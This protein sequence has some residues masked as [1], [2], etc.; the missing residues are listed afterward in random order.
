MRASVWIDYNLIATEQILAA[1]G[2]A[3][4]HKSIGDHNAVIRS[5]AHKKSCLSRQ[6]GMAAITDDFSIHCADAVSRT[7]Q[8]ICS[9]VE[10]GHSVVDMGYGTSTVGIRHNRLLI[11]CCVVSYTDNHPCAVRYRVRSK[12]LSCSVARATQRMYPCCSLI[13]TKLLCT[14]LGNIMLWLSALVLHI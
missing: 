9:V 12:S 1:C 7:H 3:L 14:R 10:R 13:A 6:G 4:C 8:T 11:G 5:L 2:C